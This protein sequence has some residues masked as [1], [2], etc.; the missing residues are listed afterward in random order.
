MGQEFTK[1]LLTFCECT[2]EYKAFDKDAQREANLLCADGPYAL[3]VSLFREPDET[4][5]QMRQRHDDG[6]ILVT[7][8]FEFTAADEEVSCVTPSDVH[9]WLNNKCFALK[10][11]AK[12]LQVIEAL[13]KECNEATSMSE[14]CKCSAL[15]RFYF[16]LNCVEAGVGSY[17]S[18][19]SVGDLVRLV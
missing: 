15:A 17:F 16:N 7:D 9:S 13:R 1:T 18:D 8:I 14:F 10:K 6:T 11:D 2:E 3:L 5:E 12:S 19:V 4:E